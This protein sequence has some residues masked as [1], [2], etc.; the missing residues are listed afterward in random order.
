[1]ENRNNT[2]SLQNGWSSS[3]QIMLPHS[4]AVLALGILSIQMSFI[5]GIPGLTLGIIAL[6][7]TSKAEGY[8]GKRPHLYASYSLKMLKAGKTCAVIGTVLSVILMFA[9]AYLFYYLFTTGN[10]H[11]GYDRYY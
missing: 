11:H 10:H 3:E 4:I 9:Y 6:S 7:L 1:M 8:H 5:Y 2:N